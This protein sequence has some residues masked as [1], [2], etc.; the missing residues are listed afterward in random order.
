MTRYSISIISTLLLTAF[1]TLSAQESTLRY[2]IFGHGMLN[3]HY[4]DYKE[5]PGVPNCCKNYTSGTGSTIGGGMLIEFP[6]IGNF[7]FSFRLSYADYSGLLESTDFIT[8]ANGSTPFTHSLNTTIPAISLQPSL[9]YEITTGL[10]VNAG[11][12]L[13]YLLNQSYTQKEIITT[14]NG[15]FFPQNTRERNVTSG[16]IKDNA[17]VMI[18]PVI[19]L[20]YEFPMN[21]KRTLL[22][23][24]EVQYQHG[25]T[26]VN[27][28]L[29]WTVST[30]RFG[31]A[32]KYS[33]K[34]TPPP[35]P[36][37]IPDKKPEQPIKPAIV[38]TP[39]QP[40]KEPIT[41]AV[42][43]MGVDQN[44]K[45]FPVAKIVVEEF[46][47]SQIRPL[48]H[49]VFFEENSAQ[50]PEKY[51]QLTSQE[52][53]SF[54][55]PSLQSESTLGTYY[56]LLNIIGKR[57]Q[58][59]PSAKLTI[60]GCN[61]NEGIEKNNVALSQQ[62]A[63]TVKNYLQKSWNIDGKRLTVLNRNLPEKP[64]NNDTQDGITENRRVELRSDTWEIIEP[65]IINDTLRTSNPPSIRFYPTITTK[66]D[67]TQWKVSVSQAGNEYKKFT[68]D[69]RPP[70]TLDWNI[71]EQ[72]ALIPSLSQPLVYEIIAENSD[73]MT[74]TSP[75]QL[76]PF[77]QITV[78]K[79]RSERR[80]D[81]EIDR[82]SLILFDY[83]RSEIGTANKKI[84]DYI[85][86]RIAP[87]AIV[88][89]TG[90]TDKIGDDVHNK[91]LSEQ[92]AQNTVKA[93]GK[94]T[95]IGE[96]EKDIFDNRLPE[97]RFYNRTVTVLVE[98]PISK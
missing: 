93:I 4:A 95:A 9:M 68:G 53:Q 58:N 89:V 42:R 21:A 62:R 82:Y 64:S 23:T 2:G 51:R 54:S 5:L 85:K 29:S 88:T 26:N 87:N 94:G 92:R 44:G 60:V 16:D 74:S 69:Q 66:A 14:A 19:G 81:K 12:D 37:P 59:N 38:N 45:E 83:D 17:A 32:L 50:I 6:F 28:S 27:N 1:S 33:P 78:Q 97:G 65:V 13:N 40:I 61:A 34:P 31:V 70:Q 11:L 67:I 20:G 77:E 7:D 80:E 63:E 72:K 15:T 75:Q 55:I 71:T 90:Y 47:S 25:I 48:L 18:A 41:A 76:L 22:L 86:P 46:L 30:I 35:K 8:T 49:Y 79:K 57:L 39:T 3:T 84:I 43:A 24:P 73:T 36:E 91:E 10:K 52:T 96:G 98:T 56:H